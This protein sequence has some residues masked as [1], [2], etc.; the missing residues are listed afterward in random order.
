[1]LGP[2][3]KFR[4]SLPGSPKCQQMQTSSQWRH[5]YKNGKQLETSFSYLGQNVKNMYIF[6]YFKGPGGGGASIIRLDLS[7]F[8]A[9]ST[10]HPYPCTCEIRK[11]SDKNF[12]VQIQKYETNIMFLYLC[13]LVGGGG[14][15]SYVEPRV[16]KFPGQ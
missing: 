7:C 15:D 6:G 16:T 5:M 10:H 14:L 9:I 13:V 4:G 8:P 1:M 11:Q 12:L 2:Y 3:I